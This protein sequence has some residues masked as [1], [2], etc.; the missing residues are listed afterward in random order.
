VNAPLRNLETAAL[1][2]VE[3]FTECC[4]VH[5]WYYAEG[6]I[7]LQA[8]VDNLQRLAAR[9]GLVDEI[10]QDAVQRLIAYE[11]MPEHASDPEIPTDY[12]ARIYAQWEADDA[13]RRPSAAP[14]P[15]KREYRTPQATVDAFWFVARQG[16]PDYL[17]RW[18]AQHPADVPHLHKIWGQKCATTT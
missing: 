3:D 16:D 17:A 6:W 8:A 5:A 10:G 2:D 14:E 15:Q 12:A 9:R 13:K 7:S 11:S 4:Q 1:G 18:L